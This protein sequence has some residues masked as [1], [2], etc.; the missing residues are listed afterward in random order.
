MSKNIIY[1]KLFIMSDNNDI[2]LA[3]LKNLGLSRDEARMYLEL[4]KEPSSHLRLS[5]ITGINR[6]KIYRMADDL[7]KRSLVAVRSDDRGTF[8]VAADPSTLE[9]EIVAQEEKLRSKRTALGKVLPLLST[10]KAGDV[11][12]FVVHTYE[13]E[14]GFKQ[15]L[16]HELKAKEELA[17]FGSGTVK[18]LVTQPM[19]TNKLHELTIEAGFRI[20]EIL[21]PQAEEP[22]SLDKRYLDRFSYRL[23]SP[24]I[25]SLKSQIVIYNDTVSTYHWRQDQKVGIEIINKDYAETQRQIFEYYWQIA[26]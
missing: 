10:I 15:M 7:E 6:T 25:L 2:L 24:E 19:W 23:I 11:S 9:V 3:H 20:R 12:N 18:D 4:L 22:F 5:R 1:V 21:N 13:G 8:L 26:R 16:W 14:Q 17:I